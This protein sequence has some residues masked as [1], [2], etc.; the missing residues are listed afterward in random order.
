VRD[1][2]D[3]TIIIPTFN[4]PDF[5]RRAVESAMAQ[6]QPCRV[7]VAND[8][9]PLPHEVYEGACYYQTGRADH[10]YL[11][12][13]DAAH[14]ANTPYVTVLCDDDWLEPTFLERCFELMAPDVAF[15]FTE[16]T[17]H[18]RDGT[19][20]L[21]WGSSMRGDGLI[22]SEI[23]GDRL[24]RERRIVTPSCCL[25]R[26]EDVLRC[27]MPGGVPGFRNAMKGCAN[28]SGPD[29]ALALF[30]LLYRPSVGYISDPLVNLDAG[31]Q[32]TTMIELG[33]DS[34]CD[35]HENY[36]NARL[37]YHAIRE[38]HRQIGGGRP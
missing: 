9:D 13:Y 35:L 23:I 30:A 36:D 8:G 33:R 27:L 17:V 12:V 28:P 37:A 6:T 18:H 15:V 25:Y 22:R 19:T 16:S 20:E 3:T 31:E 7:L 24:L 4:R 29:H 14:R 11:T 1:K 38:A 10:W 2:N 21:H 32:S 26:R 34:G 5:C